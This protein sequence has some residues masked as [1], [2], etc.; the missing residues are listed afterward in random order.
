MER[1]CTE[2]A[3]VNKKGKKIL[4]LTMVCLMLTPM[5][6]FATATTGTGDNA[7]TNNNET[8]AGDDTTQNN[9]PV[10]DPAVVEKPKRPLAECKAEALAEAKVTNAAELEG[11][12]LVGT[13]STHEL[14][15][16]KD[17]LAIIVRDSKTGAIMESVVSDKKLASLAEGGSI[18][19]E[20]YKERVVSSVFLSLIEKTSTGDNAGRLVGKN[21]MKSTV[22]VSNNGFEAD[23]SFDSYG[24][25]LKLKVSIDDKGIVVEIPK[26]SVKED[27]SDQ[28][29]IN[30]LFV[31]PFLGY[32]ELNYREGYMIV[33]D[34]TGAIINLN[35][36]EGKY[37]APYSQ[38]IYG[39]DVAVDTAGSITYYNDSMNTMKSAE[40]VVMPI[41]GMVH[42]DTQMAVLGVIEDG[43]YNAT[44]QAYPNAV[45]DLNWI[46]AKYLYR[47]V[48]GEPL[49]KSTSGEA[50]ATVNTAQSTLNTGDIKLRYIFTSGDEADYAG[51]AVKYRQL[52]TDE[53]ILE[54]TQNDFKVRL[55]FLGTDKENF[56][57]F[58]RS[59]TMTTVENIRDIIGEL[60]D[61]NVSNILA[62][63]NGWQKGGVYNLPIS[64]YKVDGS[65]GGKSELNKLVK[66]MN[67]N[68]NVDFYLNSDVQTLNP[69]TTDSTFDSIKKVDK[70]TYE[71]VDRG[72]VVYQKFRLT[73]PYKSAEY[74]KNLSEDYKDS[75]I[76]NMAISGITSKLFAYSQKGQ[77]YSRE[78]SKTSYVEA[79]E[80]LSSDNFKIALNDPFAYMWKYTDAY[81]D[82]PL[83]TSNYLFCDRDVPFL[84][85]VLKGSIPMY[86]EYVNF[87]ANKTEFFLKLV[88]AGVAP[89]FYLTHRSPSYLQNT[90]SS[91]V[92]TSEY[93]TYKDMIVK[94]YTRLKELSDQIGDSYIVDHETTPEGVNIT[95]YENGLKVYVNYSKEDITVNGLTI[96]GQSY[97]VGEA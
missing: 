37:A 19:S 16:N 14:Y 70:T 51:L 66:D 68:D 88:E 55:D 44:I 63:Y 13:N 4:C 75:G 29:V 31:Y 82:T 96:Q 69:S 60:Q 87:E 22:N 43:E 17:S 83:S 26:D 78:V 48:I 41:W 93:A 49:D 53:G 2:L 61:E 23:V 72:N 52:L 38:R 73:F 50:V 39:G 21:G 15:L 46:T 42:T 30:E 90:N 3:R 76:T 32:T 62:I 86:S 65:I 47:A 24:I 81:L 58:K 28:F 56:L 97:K 89:S 25:S 8:V 7:T 71:S 34:G 85:I 74:L 11:Y 36:N 80:K 64:E 95:T 18:T 27:K 1:W 20:E 84:A 45:T 9:Q 79:I 54:K 94:Y 5:I 57:V 33:P 77:E 12:E 10:T 6:S 91:W 35:D 40:N 67:A 92:Y 59:V